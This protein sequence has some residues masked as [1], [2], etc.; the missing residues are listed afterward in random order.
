MG[1]PYERGGLLVPYNEQPHLWVVMND[2]CP[3]GQCLLL[4]ITTIYETR[5]TDTTCVLNVGDHPFIKHP[6]YI[7]YRLAQLSRADHVRKML[8]K[9]YYVSKEDFDVPVFDR[10]AEGIFQSDRVTGV[11]RKYAVAVGLD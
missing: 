11:V 7:A 10:I 1:L 4:M 9:K 8:A 6:S 3:D 5:K 2:E